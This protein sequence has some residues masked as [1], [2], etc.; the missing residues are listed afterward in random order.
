MIAWA[1]RLPARAATH[2]LIRYGLVG[3]AN[4]GIDY[5]SFALLYGLA[6]LPVQ[7]AHIPGYV[8]G[9]AL[10]F[11]L[12]KSWTFGQ[13]I[14][15]GQAR[16]QALIF[17][18]VNAIGLPV[19]I[20]ILSLLTPLIGGWIAKLATTALMLVYYYV[21]SKRVVFGLRD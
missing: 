15:D 3:M 16:R 11:F 5:A 14:G 19:S 4:N 6:G 21:A 20:A 12:N 8:A 13:R 10:S 17:V 18:V 2:R 9:T 7:I 1:R